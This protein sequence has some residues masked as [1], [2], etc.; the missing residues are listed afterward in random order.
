M[1]ALLTTHPAHGR[2]VVRSMWPSALIHAPSGCVSLTGTGDT[3]AVIITTKVGLAARELSGV[4]ALDRG[5]IG[6][7][8]WLYAQTRLR[9]GLDEF[10]GGPLR[11]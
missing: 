1:I 4:V 5:V 9:A 3:D 7:E 8:L 6:T 11:R 10:R 2:A